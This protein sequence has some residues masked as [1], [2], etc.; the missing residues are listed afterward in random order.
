MSAPALDLKGRTLAETLQELQ[1]RVRK[2]PGDA[3]LRNFL[4][5]LL[6]VLGQWDRA[7]AQL[8]VA[9][10]LDPA[11]IPMVQA[12]GDAVRCEPL[13]AEVLAGKRTP[14]LFG[15]PEPWV[16]LMFEALKREGA[17][18]FAQAVSLRAEAFEQAPATTG[19][20]VTVADEPQGDEPPAGT[21]FEWIADADSRLGPILEAVV[22]GRY[23]WIPL[24]RVQRIDFEAPADLRDLVWAPVHLIWANGG[25]AMAMLP[26][27]YPG[28]EAVDDDAI[29][30]ARRTEWNEIGDG[31]FH[32]LGQRMFATEAGESAI[33]ELKRIALDTAI[34]E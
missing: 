9:G 19:S 22:N 2:E 8:G 4:F 24:Q 11:A 33:L 10:E 3:K 5:Q 16:A 32:G 30:L 28:S 1:A 21:A 31:T 26:V 15:D 12:Y 7:L 14:V 20:I 18:E 23:L 25:E 13:R 34:A 17:G 27:R 6:A 29:R